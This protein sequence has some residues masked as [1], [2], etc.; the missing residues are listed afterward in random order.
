MSLHFIFGLTLTWDGISSVSHATLKKGFG[1]PNLLFSVLALF[2]AN[3]YLTLRLTVGTSAFRA[4]YPILL[5]LRP[6]TDVQIYLEWLPKF[7]TSILRCPREVSS[8]PY[9]FITADLVGQNLPKGSVWLLIIS[10]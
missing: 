1:L 4:F 7:S 5:S 9:A 6:A 8:F 10:F 2:I 3:C